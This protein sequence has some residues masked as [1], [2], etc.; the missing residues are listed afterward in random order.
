MRKEIRN[1]IFLIIGVVAVVMAA[2]GI[3]YWKYL[4]SFDMIRTP[5]PDWHNPGK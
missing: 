2:G 5:S 3:C 4:M 1:R